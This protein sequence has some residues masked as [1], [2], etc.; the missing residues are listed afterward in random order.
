MGGWF[1][2]TWRNYDSID[3][4]KPCISLWDC[5]A[6]FFTMKTIFVALYLLFIFNQSFAQFD[7]NWIIGQD[8]EILMDFNDSIVEIA[9]RPEVAFFTMASTNISI[10]DSSGQL[11]FYSNGC[12]I[13]DFTYEIMQ[14]G[15]SINLGIV[16]DYYCET[17]FSS[18]VLQGG[19]CLPLP[20][21]SNRYYLFNLDL[22]II[23]YDT[24][25]ALDPKRLYYHVIDMD[26]NNGLGAVVQKNSIAIEDSLS[27]ARGQLQAVRHA[28]GRDWW[29]IVPKTLSNCYHLL[30]LTPNGIEVS[31]LECA[32]EPWERRHG[33]GQAVFSPDGSKFARINPWNGLHIFDFDRC[34]GVL[35][36]PMTITFPQDTF[37]AAGVSISP[38]SR[39][40][41]ITLVTKIYQFD[42]HTDDIAGSKILIDTLNID[43]FPDFGAIFYLSQLAPDGKIY[44]A[45]ISSHLYLHVINEPDSLGTNCNFIQQ[46][47]PLPAL[48]FVSVPNFPNYNLGA[49]KAVCDSMVSIENTF[50]VIEGKLII[51]PN[52]G[53]GL[54]NLRYNPQEIQA[55][56]IQVTNITGKVLIEIPV[57][58]HENGEARFDLS[59]SGSGM[60][61]CRLVT[62]KGV[63]STKIIKQ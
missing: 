50:P 41:Y 6:K 1:F 5:T 11:L 61:I 49:T 33:I 15:D 46:G 63:L 58:Q 56:A 20:Q 12:D 45:G 16:Q 37:T 42:L 18:P 32:G 31:K 48:N 13:R 39:F 38:N 23:P 59:Q 54:F 35:S 53:T 7:T 4:K 30:L 2:P 22:D 3:N 26:M 36:N 24:T 55:S 28:N 47:V 44:I 17:G 52:P 8:G 57:S 29:V 51:Y 40:L 14:N 19:I 62:D 25:H 43:S 9:L 27:L 60:Y 10:S 34:E 21:S